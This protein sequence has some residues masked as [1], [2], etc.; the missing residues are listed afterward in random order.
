LGWPLWSFP[1]AHQIHSEW[2]CQG[3]FIVLESSRDTLQS[4]NTLWKVAECLIQQPSQEIV[5]HS[6]SLA[7]RSWCLTVLGPEEESSCQ[8]KHSSPPWKASH[9]GTHV[10]PEVTWSCEKHRL[11][12]VPFSLL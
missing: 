10:P 6:S 3:F 5:E 9:L 1:K 2:R 4:A 8:N 7:F 11:S 12:L